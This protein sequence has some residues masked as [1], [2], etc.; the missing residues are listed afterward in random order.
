MCKE[1]I[2][3]KIQNLLSKTVE[4][5]CT[6]AEATSAFEM[7]RKLMLKHKVEEAEV[8]GKT[9]SEIIQIKLTQNFTIKWLRWLIQV[10]IDNFGVMLYFQKGS[11][12][13]K[14][15]VLFGNKED[16]ECVAAIF[17]A[18][19]TYAESN[20]NKYT[21]KFRMQYGETKGIRND[22]L[23]G[24]IKGIEAK[25]EEQNKAD[26]QYALVLVTPAEVVNGFNELIS[27]P[28]FETKED[29]IKIKHRNNPQAIAAGYKDGREFGT[30]A[31]TE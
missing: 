9:V 30:T 1:N 16:V 29:N 27:A 5:G 13:K 2:I 18:A 22:Y 3:E 15:A 7:A 25:Y 20:A 19:A 26:N 31:I 23:L 28:T 17:N 21:T 14:Y 6:E 11:D 24:F 12:N 4:N 8:T 10:F